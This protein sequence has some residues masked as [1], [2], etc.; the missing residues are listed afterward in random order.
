MARRQIVAAAASTTQATVAFPH[1]IN[2]LMDQTENGKKKTCP[3][4]H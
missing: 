3:Q 1:K 2:P 4:P